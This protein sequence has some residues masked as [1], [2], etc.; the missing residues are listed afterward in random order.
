MEKNEVKQSIWDLQLEAFRQLKK[1]LKEDSLSNKIAKEAGVKLEKPYAQTM[2][3]FEKFWLVAV[4]W[5]T[6]AIIIFKSMNPPPKKG[7]HGINRYGE[8][9]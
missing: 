3:W 7:H 6:V 9:Y 4:I 2:G 5:V 8:R 1:S